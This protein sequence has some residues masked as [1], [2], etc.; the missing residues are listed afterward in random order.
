MLSSADQTGQRSTSREYS[1]G[2]AGNNGR[3]RA[4]NTKYVRLVRSVKRISFEH[5]LIVIEKGR[6][7]APSNQPTRETHS[8]GWSDSKTKTLTLKAP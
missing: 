8:A 5:N 6:N 1:F 7:D 4:I 3:N 2:G